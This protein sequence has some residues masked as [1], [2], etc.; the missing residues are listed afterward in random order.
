MRRL[1]VGF[2]AAVLLLL[3]VNRLVFM[4]KKLEHGRIIAEEVERHTVKRFT[5]K[6][7]LAET[8]RVGDSLSRL[9]DSLLHAR[10]TA[11]LR[12]GGIAEALQ[13]YPPEAYPEVQALARHYGARPARRPW[14]GEALARDGQARMLS[15]T[16]LL[17]TK[18]IYLTQTCLPCHGKTIGQNE[19]RQLKEKKPLWDRKGL[20]KGDLAGIWYI[21]VKRKAILDGL[22]LKAMKKRPGRR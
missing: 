22:T 1:L 16:E 7:I 21:P 4:P 9:A 19:A 18:P 2:V 17:Y 13:H 12:Q 5:Q 10:V 8:V 20:Q 3:L 6:Q 15:N 14:S 11:A